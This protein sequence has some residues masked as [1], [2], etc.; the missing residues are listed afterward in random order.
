MSEP[1]TPPPD[2]HDLDEF[3][4]R[5]SGL[6]RAYREA[7]G[8]TR[9]PPALDQAVL[10]Y[11]E[12]E[13]QQAAAPGAMVWYRARTP[14][15]LAASLILVVG[16]VLLARETSTFPAAGVAPAPQAVLQKSA[17]EEKAVADQ[18]AAAA[19]A[20]QNQAPEPMKPVPP[21][22]MV[23]PTPAPP[24]PSVASPAPAQAAA[25]GSI[26]R[27]ALEQRKAASA[28]APPTTA[29][30]PP[31][32]ELE[33]PALAA[34]TQVPPPVAAKAAAAP[35]AGKPE[36]T[37]IPVSAT[38]AQLELCAN[39]APDSPIDA[40]GFPSAESWYA[41]IRAEV[42]R[43]A[44]GARAQARCLRRVYPQTAPP[45]DIGKLVQ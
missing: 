43:D 32:P 27:D 11:A 12:R 16:A 40:G 17:Q 41:A 34:S 39:T 14:L 5:R 37:V 18:P 33:E 3:L 29:P 13:R 19:S 44:D 28:A 9:T 36:P 7:S 4:A 1:H 31:P 8:D 23:V 30:L 42:T 38:A 25:S 2:D 15:A 24:P 22:A 20:I 26:A 21:A 10:D 6:S 35:V 45:D